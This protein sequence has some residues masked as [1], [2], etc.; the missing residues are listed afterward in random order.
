MLEK[1][2]GSRVVLT[3][4]QPNHQDWQLR[5]KVDIFER[6]TISIVAKVVSVS[7]LGIWIEHA[8]YPIRFPELSRVEKKRADILI[9]FDFIT[10]IAYFPD[11]PSEPEEKVYPIGFLDHRDQ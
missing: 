8:D 3:I 7:D 4:A 11:M 10:S 6:S 1:I 5:P 2:V 9:R